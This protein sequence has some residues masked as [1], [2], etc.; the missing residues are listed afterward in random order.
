MLFL[1][2]AFSSTHA[3]E[4]NRQVTRVITYGYF[5]YIVNFISGVTL[6]LEE[7]ENEKRKKK[8]FTRRIFGNG[9]FKSIKGLRSPHKT[10]KSRIFSLD[11]YF[12]H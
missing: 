11:K 2:Y 10:N 5:V 1:K 4:W 9:P 12:K 6:V 7:K 8:A 3:K